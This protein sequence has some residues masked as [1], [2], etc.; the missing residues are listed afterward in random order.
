MKYGNCWL[1]A[2]P[3]FIRE[4]GHLDVRWSVRSQ[5][6]PH[7]S[8]SRDNKTFYEFVP[9]KKKWGVLEGIINSFFFKGEVRQRGK[10][11]SE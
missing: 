7:V 9:I 11:D 1:Y 5:F 4:G 2:I 8:W 6:I 10:L 3:R